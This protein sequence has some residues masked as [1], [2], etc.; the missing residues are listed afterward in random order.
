M[1]DGGDGGVVEQVDECDEGLAVPVVRVGRQFRTTLLLHGEY[2][3]C[4]YLVGAT[5]RPGWATNKFMFECKH[6]V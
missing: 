6:W 3:P 2:F 1:V 4:L 5:H